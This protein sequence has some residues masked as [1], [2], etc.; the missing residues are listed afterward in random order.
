M[1][2]SHLNFWTSVS[3][4]SYLESGWSES[5]SLWTVAYFLATEANTCITY[6]NY[7]IYLCFF[8]STVNCKSNQFEVTMNQFIFGTMFWENHNFTAAK[9]QKLLIFPDSQRK[10]QY[11]FKTSDW[12]LIRN[13]LCQQLCCNS[14]FADAAASLQWRCRR[15]QNLRP[16][17]WFCFLVQGPNRWRWTIFIALKQLYIGLTQRGKYWRKRSECGLNWLQCAVPS[18]DM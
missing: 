12:S 1:G 9:S 17:F 11:K 2:K 4:R 18:A 5:I 7:F 6:F 16:R 13:I 14:H 3:I 10:L 8:L 15:A